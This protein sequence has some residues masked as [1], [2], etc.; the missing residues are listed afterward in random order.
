MR[1]VTI[2]HAV[3]A[4]RYKNKDLAIEISLEKVAELEEDLPGALGGFDPVLCVEIV[5]P[6][7]FLVL[8][9]PEKEG[10]SNKSNK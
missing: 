1:I 7:P 2:L 6:P 10:K 9:K 3:G 5:F 8:V 4:L